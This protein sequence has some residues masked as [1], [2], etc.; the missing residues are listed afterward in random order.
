MQ[1]GFTLTP[2]L[3][4]KGRGGLSKGLYASFLA[5]FSSRMFF[6]GQDT[7][8]YTTEREGRQQ[9]VRSGECGVRSERRNGTTFNPGA[10]GSGP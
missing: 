9:A 8:H 3:S 2:A 10:P 1:P 6:H 7:N 4:H 5:I